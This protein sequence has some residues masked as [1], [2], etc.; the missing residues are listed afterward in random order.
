V[1]GPPGAQRK[2]DHGPCLF[3]GFEE[4]IDGPWGELLEPSL[5]PGPRPFDRI[6]VRAVC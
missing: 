1:P 5:R 4:Q 3:D 2:G 6:E